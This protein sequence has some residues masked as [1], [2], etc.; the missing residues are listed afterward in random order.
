MEWLE[1]LAAELPITLSDGAVWLAVGQGLLFGAACLVFGTWLARF[2]GLLESDAPAGET[3]GVG[4]ASGLLVV[5]SWWAAFASGGRSSFTPV[6]IGFAIAIA[7]TVVRR[8]RPTT[9]V[10]APSAQ[11]SA[12][13]AGRVTKPAARWRGMIVAALAGA[14]FIVAVASVYG[15]TIVLSS[16]DGV[17]PLEFQDAAFYS[18]LGADL[19]RT[20]TETIYSPSGFAGLE[21]LPVQ[22][23]Y[24][25]GEVWLAAAVISIFGTAPL[26]ARYF[27]VLPVL[28]L[29]AAALTGTVV[30]RMTGSA[31]RTAFLFGFL[32]CLFLAPMPLIAGPFFSTWPTGLIFGITSYGLAA[33]AV[34]LGF[35]GLAV[36]G[37]RT[38]SWGLASFVGSAAALIVPAHVVI[39]VLGLAGIGSVW[40]IRI[41]QSFVATRRIPRV[42]PAWQQTLMATGVAIVVTVAW[43]LL[44]GH[45][46]GG[47]GI[48][49]DVSPFNASWR[50]SVAITVICSGAFLMIGVAWVMVRKEAPLEAG[51]YLGTA[52][53]VLIG[54]FAWGARLAD[55]NSFH[56]FYG[57][58]AVFATPVAAVAVVSVWLRSRASR[59]R[60]IVV[61]ALVLCVGQLEFNVATGIVRLQ[62]FGPTGR[63]SPEPVPLVILSAIES[64]PSDSKLAY[65]CRP[66]EE[67]AFWNPSLLA[68][69]AHTGQ[70]I[71]PMCFQATFLGELTGGHMSPDIPSALFKWA[72]QRTLYPDSA[73]HPSPASV[74]SFLKDNGIGYIY[75]DTLHPNTLVPD[76]IPMVTDGEKQVLRI[77]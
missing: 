34:L 4:L 20:G 9:D 36:L 5:A 64:L 25:W 55:F 66:F 56:L 39:A 60:R 12:V 2:V 24:H 68:F 76:A 32:A 72:P 47:S 38:V 50:E 45:G 13:A 54:A 42:A 67:G 15:S 41:W 46:I 28:L 43:G 6:A 57:G 75:A 8:A 21:G 71:V 49:T 65:A 11:P 19:A 27:V 74:A 48:S 3:L 70:R 59:L 14:V 61:I 73:A 69:D 7:L 17:Q 23:W 33:V 63:L 1:A 16:R 35:Y 40:T 29:A 58:I 31:S 22:T 18:V 37:G 62:G 44:T 30:R 51:L 53:L 10:D 77:P 26:A 52:L